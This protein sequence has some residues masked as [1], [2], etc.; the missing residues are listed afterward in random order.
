MLFLSQSSWRFDKIFFSHSLLLVIFV[1]SFLIGCFF[2][3]REVCDGIPS[4]TPLNVANFH[5]LL[6][7][8]HVMKFDSQSHLQTLSNIDSSL[9]PSCHNAATILLQCFFI[10]SDWL[11]TKVTVCCCMT[12]W[13]L[14][15]NKSK[16]YLLFLWSTKP[17]R[18]YTKNNKY[19]LQM[20]TKAHLRVE[21][22]IEES[23][24]HNFWTFSSIIHQRNHLQLCSL[25]IHVILQFCHVW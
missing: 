14:C 16:K 11:E 20:V 8:N 23:P 2:M 12:F 25:L 21:A 9:T 19:L 6:L 18:M 3:Q 4:S 7:P 22:V 17:Y 10:L 5:V 13:I 24:I 1:W 15:S